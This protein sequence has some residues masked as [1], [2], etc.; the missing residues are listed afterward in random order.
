MVVT[1]TGKV[2]AEHDRYPTEVMR[3]GLR[4][5]SQ[6]PEADRRPRK[7]SGV[8]RIPDFPRPPEPPPGAIILRSHVRALERHADGQLTWTGPLSVAS[9][10][11]SYAA[12]P[13]L[14]H[15]WI[16]TSEWQAM[17]PADPRV[18]QSLRVPDSVAQ[19]LATFHLMD[20]A[21]GCGV[22]LWENAR[23]DLTLRVASVDPGTM[24]MD[25]QG[26]A[27]IGKKGDYPVRLQ[28]RLTV[29]RIRGEFTR[30]DL[31]ALG[32]DEGDMRTPEQRRQRFNIWYRV[33]PQAKL[34]MAIAF[35]LIEG[36]RPID[37][38]PPYAIM[39]DSERNYGRPYF[40]PN[41]N[42]D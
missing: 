6:L 10:E 7:V 5:W 23:A 20:K 16:L 29:D 9:G 19:R 35:E 8:P 21:L 30:F 22:F 37:R 36:S 31:I 32:Q 34:V 33:S 17:I 26:L 38:V 42:K 41:S 18:G 3:E 1:G 25:L 15:V 40:A 27:W 28:G 14:D 24:H 4:A 13:Q 12:E 11:Y 39:F 2:L